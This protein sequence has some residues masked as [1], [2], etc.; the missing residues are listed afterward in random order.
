MN[1]NKK[2]PVKLETLSQIAKRKKDFLIVVGLLLTVTIVFS[3]IVSFF[4]SVQEKKI[5]RKNQNKILKNKQLDLIP[6]GDFKENWAIS[7]ENNIKMQKDD[8]KI[9]MK[10]ISE[11]QSQN[12]KKLNN[13][14]IDSIAQQKALMKEQTKKIESKISQLKKYTKTQINALNTQ[15]K[16]LKANRQLYTNNSNNNF[17]NKQV[18]INNNNIVIGS[19]LLPKL[20]NNNQSK[21]LNNDN[22]KNSKPNDVENAINEITGTLP[23]PKKEA[24][25]TNQ[26]QHPSITVSNNINTKKPVTN[27]QN[28]KGIVSKKAS[29]KNNYIKPKLKIVSLNTGNNLQIIK[30]NKAKALKALQVKIP[31]SYYVAT[32]LSSAYL[33]T[34]VYAP[35]F[36]AGNTSPLPVLLQATGDILIANDDTA[37]IDKCF[38]IGSAKG[39]MNSQ[40]ADIRLVKISCSLDNG[41]YFV[42]GP[43][44]GWIIGENGIPGVHGTLLY[45]NGAFISKTFLAGFLQTFSQSFAGSSG[46]AVPITGQS[47]TSTGQAV[48]KNA[49][50]AAL[51]GAANVFGKIASYYLKMAQQIFPVIEVKPGR[52]VDVLLKGGDTLTVR[53]VN[54]ASIDTMEKNV[55]LQEQQNK[56]NQYQSTTIKA[57]NVIQSAVSVSDNKGNINGNK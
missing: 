32:G 1:K 4:F 51:S 30:E 5:Y 54:K 17:N 42:E 16:I 34:G 41:K 12:T 15:I 23:A 24:T 28:N 36:S 7:V 19:D 9:F 21:K 53:K 50:Y 44:S 43:I 3:S 37:S 49:Q 8:L 39:N 57:K 6:S 20:P 26:N 35:V 29:K 55:I 46:G 38:L 14:M 48:Q 25:T 13:M 11:E 47:S 18:P 45:K 52:T 40:T 27:K 33:I 56:N 10:K 22:K 2:K 31:S